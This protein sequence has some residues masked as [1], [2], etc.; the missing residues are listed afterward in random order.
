MIK[1][2]WAWLIYLPD[3]PAVPVEPE[4]VAQVV[5]KPVVLQPTTVQQAEFSAW[6]A[7]HIDRWLADPDN[8]GHPN[9]EHLTAERDMHLA[10]LRMIGVP[11]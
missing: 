11:A 2:F 9:T 10:A 3:Y 6:R 8:L 7:G 4:A 5:A 1:R